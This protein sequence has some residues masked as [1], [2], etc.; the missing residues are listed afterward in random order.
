M[1]TDYAIKAQKIIEELSLEIVVKPNNI[2][3]T[4]VKTREVIRPA[5]EL[6]GFLDYYNS[7]RILVLGHTEH[8]Y[9]KNLTKETRKAAIE[10]L[11]REKPPMLIVCS[12]LQVFP[13]LI[14]SARRNNVLLLKTE[15]ET[16]D[17]MSD[18]LALLNFELGERTT[19]H[20]VLMEVYGQGIL[21]VGKSGIGK[22]E[23]AI[24]MI[25]RGHR[26]VADDAVEIRRI[27]KDVLLGYAPENI[28]HYVELRGIGIINASRIFGMGSIKVSCEIDVVLE[29]EDWD[30]NKVYDRIGLVDSMVN[31]LGVN[32][33][34]LTIPIKPGRNL[35]VL[36]EVAALNSRQKFLGYN[37]AKELLKSLGYDDFEN[38]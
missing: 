18:L 30:E 35:S 22:S 1:G 7:S 34:S 9:L 23:T 24:E 28:R 15:S 33:P 19:W 25:K 31:I 32:V 16:L 12:D 2:D 29:L 20:G 36:M 14:N 11:L 27:S 6:A 5:L 21:I 13:E 3:D 8:A 38:Q 4:E 26:L 10:R 37:A 17:F